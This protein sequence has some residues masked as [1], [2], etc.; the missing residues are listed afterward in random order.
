MT[1]AERSAQ[2]DRHPPKPVLT[3]R[4][5]ITGH[6]PKPARFPS[7]AFERVS[8]QLSLVF[9]AIDQAL[10]ELHRA[11]ARFYSSE[12]HRVRLVTGM[13]EGA[14]Q[15]AVW[16][17]PKDWEVEAV[18]VSDNQAGADQVAVW[19][20]PDGWAVDAI[21][22]FPRDSYRKDFEKSAA[23]E[24]RNVQADFDAALE[25]ADTIL[26]LPEIEDPKERDWGYARLGSFLIWQVDVLVAV[27]DGQAEEGPGGT[28]AVIRQAVSAHVPV[29]WIATRPEAVHGPAF[30]RMIEAF[31]RQGE[32]VAPAADCTAG[33]LKDAISTIVSLPKNV[34]VSTFESGGEAGAPRIEQKLSTFLSENWPASSRWIA[35]DLYRRW[36]EGRC[37]RWK[38]AV[39]VIAGAVD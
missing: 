4:V 33:R 10:R 20:R 34:E 5:G 39:A 31:E 22:P 6:R 3:L 25:E 1:V 30:P 2:D 36:I 8:G 29:V 7:D 35:Y 37:L 28:A 14:D 16:A 15:M 18:V 24:S 9:R 32:P 23:D 19:T 27:W 26:E 11:N 12:P 38:I 13:A 21:L 17:R